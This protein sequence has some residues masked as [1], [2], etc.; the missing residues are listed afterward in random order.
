MLHTSSRFQSQPENYHAPLVSP[1]TATSGTIRDSTALL[2]GMALRSDDE[3]DGREHSRIDERPDE[4]EDG[5]DD[6]APPSREFLESIAVPIQGVKK[7]SLSP[8][9]GS[10]TGSHR[11]HG[12]SNLSKAMNAT[13]QSSSP[14]TV[15][16]D[17]PNS[18]PITP[19]KEE[20]NSEETPLLGARGRSAVGSPNQ[21]RETSQTSSGER[22]RHRDR[23]GANDSGISS[24]SAAS[25]GGRGS[26]A[27]N[28]SSTYG[29]GALA[30]A[31]ALHHSGGRRQSL[32][33]PHH[34]TFAE[35]D[36]YHED[37]EQEELSFGWAFVPPRFRPGEGSIP[38]D[39]PS[40][41]GQ[42]KLMYASASKLTWKDAAQ[43]SMEPIRLLPAVILGLLLNV[44]DGV[45]YGLIIFPTS[46]PIFSDFGGDGV[47]MFFVT[48]V[49]SQLVFSLGGS[50]FKGGNGSMMIE[51][52]PFYHILVTIIIDVL[53]DEDP[54]AVVSTTI[55]AFALSSIFAGIV[56]FLLGYFRLGVLVG[57]FP[58]HILVGCIGGVGVFLIETGMEVSG[59]LKSED[60]FQWNLDTF[61]FFTQNWFMVAHW[62][63]AL[64]LAILLRVITHRFHHPL[65]FPTYFLCI[66]IIFYLI[67]KGIF[68]I[69]LDSL[70]KDD[71]VFDVG[72]AAEAPFWRFY[73]Y[74]D[75]TKTSGQALWATMPTQLALTFFSILHVPLNV[76]ALAVSVNEDNLDTDRELLAHGFS[77]ILAGLAGS[78]PNYLCYVN[79][80]LF[81][82]VGGG[83]R[84]SGIMLAGATFCV[85]LSGPGAIG[86]LPICVVGSLIFGEFFLSFLFTLS[87]KR[88]VE[89]FVLHLHF[90]APS[91]R[92]RFDQGSRLGYNWSSQFLGIFYHL[93]H[94][95]CHDLLRF[96][97]GNHFR[98]HCGLFVFCNSDISTKNGSGCFGR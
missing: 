38:V 47:S 72:K 63:P 84:L 92:Y 60:G 16:A 62:L 35:S 30:Q 51:V 67:T 25:G 14:A 94:H 8:I 69:P 12:P 66:P 34:V 15:R 91:S 96:C 75:F 74:F 55:V 83:S 81:Y 5:D 45:S 78:V 59:Q 95:L 54:A 10:F 23:S 29:Y 44:L 85:L 70:R 97:C 71:W 13:S 93:A 76:P 22:D 82:R 61:H 49:I 3:S 24:F 89:M 53:G 90:L 39:I 41:T 26:S 86:Y 37:Y 68:R 9:N 20:A 98:H 80:V 40:L 64:G 11:S 19:T 17:A 43:A 58:R 32:A 4:E 6:D 21:S 27:R 42:A 33:S 48:C 57:F 52:V 7:E 18:A 65:I 28:N 77:N 79:S 2:A 56:F 50:I 88:M 73:T 31:S 1:Y 46:Y 87:M 36:I